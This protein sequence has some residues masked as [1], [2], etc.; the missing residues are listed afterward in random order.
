M[1]QLQRKVFIIVDN[2]N[3]MF[4]ISKMWNFL[5]HPKFWLKTCLA[6]NSEIYRL[7]LLQYDQKFGLNLKNVMI[8]LFIER[9][10]KS[11]I[12]I[13]LFDNPP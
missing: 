1:I 8:F 10:D 11:A 7:R 12:F 6:L 5:V 3:F 4:S 2:T 13:G 9:I